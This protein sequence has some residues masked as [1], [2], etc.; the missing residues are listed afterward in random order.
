M[1]ESID[2][3][4]ALFSTSFLPYSQTFVY[5]EIRAHRRYDVDVFCKERLNADRFPYDRIYKPAG[6]LREK[7]YEN[8]AYW[9]A[10]DRILAKGGH[11]LVHAHFG[12]GAVYAL[13]YV[14]KHRLPFI[15]TFHGN[16][17]AALIGPQRFRPA[18]WRYVLRAKKIMQRADLM[19]A[20][21][22]EFCDILSSLSGRPD[23][24]KLYRIGVDLA[25]FH[26]SETRSSIPEII[27]VG[28]FTEKKGH[29]YALR[30]FTHVI[31]KGRTAHLTLVGDGALE[32]ECRN[33]VAREDL[34][35]R[36]TFAG[37]LPPERTAEMLGAADI[38]LAPSVVARNG[39]REGSPIVVR[40]AGACEVPVIGTRHSGIP[41]S[42]EDGVTGYLV[43]ERDAT[44]LADKLQC[45]IDDADL[46][47]RMGV[48]AR[49]KM[50]REFDLFK[51]VEILES[52]YDSVR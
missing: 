51:Q 39:D 27:M 1:S 28:R 16:D 33:Y 43:R 40:E 49:A 41:E 30:A 23:A 32:D 37:S 42:I 10:F 31:R 6:S 15:V 46:R 24:V 36:V 22:T 2:G 47:R 21:S 3:T 17:V 52:H 34:S 35:E 26:R 45:L 44:A 5:D 7:L 4:V 11:A 14:R 9:P 38:A 48:A 8:M 19:L 50:E 13:P 29:I 20:V 25:R 12:T 18:R